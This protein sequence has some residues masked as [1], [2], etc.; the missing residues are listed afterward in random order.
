MWGPSGF[1]CATLSL[2][3]LRA[4]GPGLENQLEWGSPSTIQG[5]K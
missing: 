1:G 5:P 4:L 3:G 2:F